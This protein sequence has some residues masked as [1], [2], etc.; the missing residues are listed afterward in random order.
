MRTDNAEYLQGYREQ[1]KWLQRAPSIPEAEHT[2]AQRQATLADEP[3]NRG[4][5][6]ATADYIRRAVS[7]CQAASETPDQH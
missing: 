1:A 2:L 3:Y 4:G 7:D 5:T 6:Q